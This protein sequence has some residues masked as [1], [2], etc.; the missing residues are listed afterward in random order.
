MSLVLDWPQKFYK[1][2]LIEMWVQWLQFDEEAFLHDNQLG[3]GVKIAD[4]IL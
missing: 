3:Q 1:V 4:S 2:F